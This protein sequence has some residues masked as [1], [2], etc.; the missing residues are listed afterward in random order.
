MVIAHDLAVEAGASFRIAFVW[1]IDDVPR[2]LTGWD[3][4]LQ[5][6]RAYDDADPTLSLARGTGLTIDDDA[7]RIVVNL[8]P[9]QTRALGKGTYVYDLLMTDPA[10]EKFRLIG[11]HV[12]VSPA[13]TR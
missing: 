4:A 8:T 5:L 11:G 10:G 7:G 2:P 9:D 1:Q 12:A 3:A 6:R 13:V